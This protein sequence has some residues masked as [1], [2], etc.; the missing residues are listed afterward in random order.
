MEFYKYCASGNDFVI[1]ADEGKKDRL[2]DT[3]GL[4]PLTFYSVQTLA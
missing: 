2:Q 3:K 4:I 1:Y